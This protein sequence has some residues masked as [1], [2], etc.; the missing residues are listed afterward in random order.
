MAIVLEQFLSS[1]LKGPQKTSGPYSYSQARPRNLPYSLPC[2]QPAMATLAATS[3]SNSVHKKA[4]AKRAAARGVTKETYL[5]KDID[6]KD[7]DSSF[8]RAQ[9][10]TLR[11]YNSQLE[12][13]KEFVPYQY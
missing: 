6:T 8:G 1:L 11:L 12:S 9:P 5:N 3:S 7:S 10:A 2:N 4:R 13:W